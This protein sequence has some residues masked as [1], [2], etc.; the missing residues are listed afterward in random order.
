[1]IIL[2]F[3]DGVN[4]KITFRKLDS[5]VISKTEEEDKE[6]SSVGLSGCVSLKPA[7]RLSQPG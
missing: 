3:F 4:Y 2:C 1:M 5:F 7:L 6:L